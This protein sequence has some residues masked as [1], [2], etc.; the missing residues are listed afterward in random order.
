[1]RAC[2][3]DSVL[4]VSPVRDVPAWAFVFFAVGRFSEY[5]RACSLLSVEPVGGSR[6]CPSGDRA[7]PFISVG[8]FSSSRP[9]RR[10][11]RLTHALLTCFELVICCLLPFHRR[12]AYLVIP[13]KPRS[14]CIKLQGML[15]THVWR[16]QIMQTIWCCQP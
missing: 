10:H 12:G 8:Y 15:R 5:C 2:V 6:G 9:K 11:V 4:N 3:C 16:I 1:M 14:K 7:L 13:N